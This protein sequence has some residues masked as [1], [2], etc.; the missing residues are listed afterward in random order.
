M[1]RLRYLPSPKL[2]WRLP[3]AAESD[4]QI[5]SVHE[6]SDSATLAKVSTIWWLRP[7][8][9]LRSC[10][11]PP[12]DMFDPPFET[13]EASQNGSRCQNRHQSQLVLR[14]T[15]LPSNEP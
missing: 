8:S 5:F 15:E 10:P 4:P 14:C 12:G 3:S 9:A 1:P 6:R 2:T 11:M 7:S 13:P